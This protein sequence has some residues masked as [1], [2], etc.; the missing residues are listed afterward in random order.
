MVKAPASE[1]RRAIAAFVDH[2][3]HERHASPHTVSAYR[4]DLDGLASFAEER[5]GE[6]VT[7]AA[8]DRSL[9]RV[10]R[11]KLAESVKPVTIGRKLSCFRALFGFLERRGTLRKNP[12]ALLESP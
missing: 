11:G 9:L 6:T 1:L 8:I 4:R 12:A 10:Y 3:A 2:L 7:L 5:L